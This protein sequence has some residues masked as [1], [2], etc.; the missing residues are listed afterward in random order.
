MR[1][2]TVL[3]NG[4]EYTIQE[5]RSRDNRQWRAELEK[6]FDELARALDGADAVDVTD[7]QALGNLVRGLS[8]KLLRSVDIICNL[9]VAYDGKLKSVVDDAY[10]SEILNAFTAVLGL[11]YPFGG[12]LD[13]LKRI[14]SQLPRT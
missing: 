6:H 1:Q 3:L 11:A 14:G 8:G 2:V 4:T 10:D 12:L 5:M 7:G 9:L 13:Q